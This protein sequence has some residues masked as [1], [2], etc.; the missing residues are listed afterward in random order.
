VAYLNGGQR[1]QGNAER[2]LGLSIA[3]NE[4]RNLRGWRTMNVF[5]S[6]VGLSAGG[7]I[8]SSF[9]PGLPRRFATQTKGPLK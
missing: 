5:F 6:C 9:Q 2:E 1:D 3:K 4:A 7:A 8:V